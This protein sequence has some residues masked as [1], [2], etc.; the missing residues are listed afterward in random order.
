MRLNPKRKDALLFLCFFDLW[1]FG[2]ILEHL[3]S[4]TPFVY[5]GYLQDF[6]IKSAES[7][8]NKIPEHFAL[9]I[10]LQ[11]PDDRRADYYFTRLHTLNVFM[12]FA[13]ESSTVQLRGRQG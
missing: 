8:V 4:R 12:M 13:S 10:K 11:K 5:A 7:V 3:G 1:P 6:L 9:L 2:G